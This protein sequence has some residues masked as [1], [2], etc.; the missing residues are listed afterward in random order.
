MSNLLYISK[1]DFM[2]LYIVNA[3]SDL[4]VHIDGSDKA[5]SKLIEL[6]KNI[7]DV[8]TIKKENC[9]KQKEKNNKEKNIVFLNKFNEQL[10]NKICSLDDGLVITIG[11]DHSVAI[12]SGLAS[13]KKNSNIGVIWID[14]HAD[15]HTF[16]TT[17]SGNIHGMPF[18]TICGQNGNK[19]S[20]FFDGN[21]FNP[22]NT[23]LVGGRDIEDGEYEN[24]KKAG[25][26]IITTDDIKKY[27]VVNV[28]KKAIKIAMQNTDGI[29][30]SY[31]IDV[32]DPK[33]APGVSVKAKN[34]INVLEAKEILNELLNQ[35]NKIKSID[36]V[37]YNPDFDIDN[38]TYNITSSLLEEIINK[39]KAID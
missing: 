6:T 2:K 30:V 11:G 27:G 10:Y 1:G 39:L 26:T 8:Y 16:D 31:D 15:Y 29:H 38:K 19:L 3:C 28:I 20:Y 14:S 34:G 35:K 36:L 33:I 32:I 12:S 13:K 7:D 4:G 9:I 25:T 37:E 18:A 17:I 21:Y 5:P 23:V 24:L 22:K